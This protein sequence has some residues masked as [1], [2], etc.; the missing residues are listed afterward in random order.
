MY[1]KTIALLVIVVVVLLVVGFY[2]WLMLDPDSVDVDCVVDNYETMNVTKISHEYLHE[3]MTL[4]YI[5][6]LYDM[7]KP[8][9]RMMLKSM[10]NI[11]F[12][13]CEV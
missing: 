10:L 1:K 7:K 11:L 5:K 4:S 13:R 3:D 8:Q 12:K 6:F 2:S 9:S